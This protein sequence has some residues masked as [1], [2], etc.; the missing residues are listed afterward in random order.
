MAPRG[1]SPSRGAIKSKLSGSLRSSARD[2]TDAEPR[3]EVE[4]LVDQLRPVAERE[5]VLRLAQLVALALQTRPVPV[6][7]ARHPFGAELE[8]EQ[9]VEPQFAAELKEPALPL[10]QLASFLEC[11]RRIVEPASQELECLPE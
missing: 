6:F 5:R 1:G 3:T 10:Q 2:G 7:V 8:V 9:L 4:P 11:A